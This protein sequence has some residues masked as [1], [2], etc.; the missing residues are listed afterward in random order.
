MGPPTKALEYLDQALDMYSRAGAIQAYDM[1]YV[2]RAKQVMASAYTY[3]WL[4]V[5]PS[6]VRLCVVR[7]ECATQLYYASCKHGNAWLHE[8]TQCV[9]WELEH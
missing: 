3:G 4:L 6:G 7:V 9:H 2:Y 1:S 5:Y 8:L